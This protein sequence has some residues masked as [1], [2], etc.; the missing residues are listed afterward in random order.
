MV[1]KYYIDKLVKKY[2]QY[3]C[4]VINKQ[5]FIYLLIN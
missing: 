1:I 5:F 2:L 4:N 3:D